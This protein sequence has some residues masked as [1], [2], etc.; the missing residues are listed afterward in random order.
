[1]CF[2]FDMFL[3]LSSYALQ[4]PLPLLLAFGKRYPSR[5]EGLAM[6]THLPHADFKHCSLDLVAAVIVFYRVPF[7][8]HR[9]VLRST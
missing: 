1:M 4:T 7:W 3:H 9:F 8:Q 6:F 5:K 2:T